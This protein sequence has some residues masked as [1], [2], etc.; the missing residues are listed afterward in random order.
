MTIPITNRQT[1]HAITIKAREL[2]GFM[3]NSRFQSAILASYAKI[4]SYEF[5]IIGVHVLI[6]LAPPRANAAVNVST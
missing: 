4:M 2:V 1:R 3:N 6:V 5:G